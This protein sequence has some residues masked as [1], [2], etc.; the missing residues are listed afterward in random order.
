VPKTLLGIY[1]VAVCTVIV[2]GFYGGELAEGIR[3]PEGPK[4]Y[5]SGQ[6]VFRNNCIGCHPGGANNLKPNDVLWG[7]P[8]LMSHTA[9]VE[10]IRSGGS[11]KYPPGR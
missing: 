7:S 3:V 11:S 9:F 5:Q 8:I 6:L 4:K 2:L 10:A 1:P